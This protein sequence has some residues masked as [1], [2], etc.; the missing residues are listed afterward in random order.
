MACMNCSTFLYL[1]FCFIAIKLNAQAFEFTFGTANN[2]KGFTNVK[3][4][5]AYT[6][7]KG[8]G[9]EFPDQLD[10]ASQYVTS[11]KPIYFSIELPEGNYNVKVLLG[12]KNGTSLTTIKAE[13]RRLMLEKVA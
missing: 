4:V 9:F 5:D 13:C 3:A 6:R 12:D 8:Y 7:G 1:L 10:F 2:R 11:S